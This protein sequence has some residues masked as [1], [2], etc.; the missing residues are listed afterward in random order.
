MKRTLAAAA[1]CLPLL[2]G[3][4][5]ADEAADHPP[6][7][8]GAGRVPPMGYESMPPMMYGGGQRGRTPY[9]MQPGTGTGPQGAAAP[10]L[11]Q[12]LSPEMMQAL[13]PEMMQRMMAQQGLPMG[14]QGMGRAAGNPFADPAFRQCILDNL[15]KPK[16]SAAVDLLY[17]TCLGMIEPAPQPAQ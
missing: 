17:M 3:P 9:G 11:P 14:P 10:G 7:G 12:G 1:V 16:S 4:A 13:S 15:D 8:S 6:A 5:P 2:A